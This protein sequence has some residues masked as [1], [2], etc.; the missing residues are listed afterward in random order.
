MLSLLSDVFHGKVLL[1]VDPEV[2]DLPMHI[3]A[4]PCPYYGRISKK[5]CGIV[6]AGQDAESEGPATVELGSK[7]I[8]SNPEFQ[9]SVE[10]ALE[11]TLYNL[12]QEANLGEFQWHKYPMLV[13]QPNK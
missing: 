6:L 5:K 12:M 10:S 7:E 2:I 11:G 9:N 3:A 13:Q 1:T 8:I 4:E